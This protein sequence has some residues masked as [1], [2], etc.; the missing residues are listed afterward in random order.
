MNVSASFVAITA[1]LLA[2]STVW[3]EDCKCTVFP[4]EP[5][6]PCFDHCAASLLLE[7]DP[8]RLEAVL[9]LPP[10]LADKLQKDR[11]NPGQQKSMEAL[12]P[13][14][15]EAEM[16]YISQKVRNLSPDEFKFLL[17]SAA[18]YNFEDKPNLEMR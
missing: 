17:D 14:F 18:P 2:G 11:E 5:E 3:A 8:E 7:A 10:S 9:D 12:S 6:P 1:L 15:D 4:F 13:S 16:S